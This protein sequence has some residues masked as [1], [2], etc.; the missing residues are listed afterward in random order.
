MQNLNTSKIVS[1]LLL[2]FLVLSCSDYRD[3]N[4]IERAEEEVELAVP[5]VNTEFEVSDFTGE[6]AP[7]NVSIRVDQD[8]RV[9]LIYNGDVVRQP[10]AEIFPPVPFFGV[11]LEDTSF[12][13][14]IPFA[15]DQ[16][17]DRAI[18]GNSKFSVGFTSEFA[19]DIDV[20]LTIPQ[21]SKD[22]NIFEMDLTIPYT[23]SLPNEYNSEFTSVEDWV[24]ISED[25]II[26]IIYDARLSDGTRVKFD[27]AF[28]IFDLVTF[29]YIEG[30]FGSEVFDIQGDFIAI[31][32]LDNWVSGGLSFEDPKVK[33][34][35]ENAF[36]FPVRSIF[37]KMQV[38]TTTGEFLDMESDVIDNNVDFNYPSLDEIGQIKITEFSFNRDNSNIVDLFKEKVVRVTYDIDAG[39]NPDMD[40]SITGF[41]NEDSYFLVNV[42]VELPLEGTVNN[43]VLQDTVDLDMSDFED[44]ISAE[45]KN[46]ITNDFPADVTLQGYFFDGNNVLLDS[47]FKERLLLPAA[48][49]NPATGRT[50]EG[51]DVITFEDFEEGRFENLKSGKKILVNVKINTQ[52][53]SSGPLWIYND[54]GV[55]FKIGAKLKTKY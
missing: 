38:V 8:D 27:D 1:L 40:E 55:R 18:F 3:L 39:A 51:A 42:D 45:F 24:L 37:K 12:T 26:T 4:D 31:G 14:P 17:V 25:N 7:E 2:F 13:V 34:F 46:V 23:G 6:N 22:G 20:K 44:V 11:Q 52:Q 36:G 53:A 10:V 35:V 32:V 47:L 41:V 50:S 43:L 5:L 33:V 19:E 9:T 28:L 48:E 15:S 49:V 29:D 30:Y 54:Y 16:R 21:L